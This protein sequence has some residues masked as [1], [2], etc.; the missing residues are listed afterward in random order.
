MS[1]STFAQRRLWFMFGSVVAVAAAVM[2][3]PVSARA[4][5]SDP[6]NFPLQSVQAVQ[7]GEPTSAVPSAAANLSIV[8][9]WHVIYTSQGQ[10]FLE[11]LDQW[12]SDGTEFE[13]ANAAPGLGNVCVGVWKQVGPVTVKLNHI[14]WNFNPDGS[15]AG[16]FTLTEVNTI[17]QNGNSYHGT[18][19]F[20]V[21]DVNGNLVPG[22]EISGRM[23]A[24]RITV[25]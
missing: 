24:S 5:C 4:A 8:G 23:T 17:S 3:A 22:S 14:G 6:R 9:L 11:T 13:M 18:F 2:F 19:T 12:H 16:Y 7:P 10:L 21:F 1:I 25:N 15:S 20:K